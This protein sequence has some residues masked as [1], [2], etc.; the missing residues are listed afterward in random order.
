MADDG[1]IFGRGSVSG[2]TSQTVKNIAEITGG[3]TTTVKGNELTQQILDETLMGLS[4][5]IKTG[6]QGQYSKQQAI[7]DT[8]MAMTSAI[9]SALAAGA[10]AV[11]KVGSSAGAYDNTTQQMMANDLTASAAASGAKVQT[12][13]IEDYAKIV[14]QGAN[15]ALDSLM[16]AI[17]LEQSALSTT[18]KKEA[19]KRAEESTSSSITGSVSGSDKGIFD[20]SMLSFL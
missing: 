2:S 17:Q 10:P 5:F 6:G 19:M 4:G 11:N 18:T 15:L 3:L 8:E 12:Q 16:R 13:A 20:L 7:A 1:G 14:T 9:N